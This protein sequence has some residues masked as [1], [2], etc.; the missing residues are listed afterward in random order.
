MKERIK[1]TIVIKSIKINKTCKPEFKEF[2]TPSK[3]IVVFKLPAEYKLLG[4]IPLMPKLLKNFIIFR[5]NIV[6]KILT[7]IV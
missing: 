7:A 6:P 4:F 5:L 3:D 2:F 1:Q